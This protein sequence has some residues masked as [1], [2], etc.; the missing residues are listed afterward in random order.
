MPDKKSAVT[1]EAEAQLKQALQERPLTFLHA[2]R[3]FG[4]DTDKE[5]VPKELLGDRS[6]GRVKR[7]LRIL[8]YHAKRM[9]PEY[10]SYYEAK[11]RNR[12]TPPPPATKPVA[13]PA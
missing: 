13:V 1:K 7:D 2:L 4:V 12:L 3:T 8:R 9:T 6:A 10:R 5:E 11:C